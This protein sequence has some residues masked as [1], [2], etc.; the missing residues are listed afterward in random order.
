[1]LYSYRLVPKP[2]WLSFTGSGTWVTLSPNIYYPKTINPLVYPEL[3]EHEKLHISQQGD[4]GKWRWLFKYFTS[5]TFRFEQEV[6]AYRVELWCVSPNRRAAMVEEMSNW[7]SS[8][9]YF[10]CAS[11]EQAINALSK[12]IPLRPPSLSGVNKI[13]SEY[14]INSS[15][16]PNLVSISSGITT[17][18]LKISGK[19]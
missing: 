6:E 15:T 16:R 5:D 17:S 11:K 14:L 8:S 12:D 13:L 4:M 3:V 1:M 7:L 9:T 10:W 19:I 18:D 2:W